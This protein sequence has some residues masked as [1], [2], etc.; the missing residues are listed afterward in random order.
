[1]NLFEILHYIIGMVIVFFLVWIIIKLNNHFSKDNIALTN[2]S[3]TEQFVGRKVN[4]SAPATAG[5]ATT[6]TKK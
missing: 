5:T 6:A 4:I 2:Q 1:M 3:L